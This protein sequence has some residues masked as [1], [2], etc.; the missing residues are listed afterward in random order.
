MWSE[1][2]FVF[3]RGFHIGLSRT[4]FSTLPSSTVTFDKSSSAAACAFVICAS[5]FCIRSRTRPLLIGELYHRHAHTS[6]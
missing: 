5:C 6:P 3:S 1:L 2:H 4:T